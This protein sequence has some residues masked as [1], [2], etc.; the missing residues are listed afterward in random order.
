MSYDDS[1]Q[2][3]AAACR[4]TAGTRPSRH[5]PTSTT[6]SRHCG[7]TRGPA[8][9]TAASGDGPRRHS[10][11]EPRAQHPH[12]VEVVVEHHQ[13]GAEAHLEGTHPVAQADGPRRGGGHHPRGVGDRDS[14]VHGVPQRGVHGQGAAGDRAVAGQSGHPVGDGDGL[15]AQLVLAVGHSGGGHRVGDQRGPVR[16]GGRGGE[17]QHAVVQVHPVGDQLA[18]HGGRVEQGHHRPRLAVVHR[19][20][21]VEQVGAD[22]GAGG[23]RG[24]GLLVRGVGVADRRDHPLR[25]EQLDRLQRAVALRGEGD[26]PDRAP[27]Q[28]DQLGQLVGR[29][30]AQVLRVLR[31]AAGGRQVRPLEV[32]ARQHALV[33]QRGERLGGRAHQR[34]GRADQ[35][36]QQRGGAVREVEVGRRAGLVGVAGG[37]GV[38]ATA[39]R[40]HVDEAG[41]DPVP[42]AAPTDTRPP[43]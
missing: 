20:H 21:P 5:R 38:P 31:A 13:V 12:H 35:A 10:T 2:A 41:H 24:A 6:S 11:Q 42:V 26:H 3:D 17:G 43:L 7:D 18:D 15:A 16:A 1:V 8:T 34:K 29:R 39:V 28:L 23:D 19:P 14:G 36:G 40:V 30:V 22:A 4:P 33:D 9:P 27:A 37:E 32:D 25:G